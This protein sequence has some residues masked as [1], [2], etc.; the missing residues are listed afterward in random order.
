[1]GAVFGGLL[2]APGCAGVVDAARGASGELQLGVLA[3]T[4]SFAPS[5]AQ[6]GHYLPYFQAVYDP[7]IRL[8]PDGTV[9]PSLAAAWEYD[10]T[11]TRLSLRLRTDVRFTDGSPCD[12]AAIKANLDAFTADNGPLSS[13]LRLVERVETPAPDIAVVVLSAPDPGL[14]DS[15]GS[16]GGFVAS[17]AA[18]GGQ[19]L[20][21]R[22]VGSGPYLLDPAGTTIGVKYTFVRNPDH[23]GEQLPFERVVLNVIPDGRARLNALKAGQLDGAFTASASDA[24]EA[25]SAGLV[26]TTGPVNF[27][28]LIMFDRAGRLTPALADV[29][30]RRALSVAINREGILRGILLGMGERTGQ[31]FRP[32]DDGYLPELDAAF[33]YDPG[34]ARRLLAEAGHPGGLDIDF[35]VYSSMD[36]SIA[37]AIIANWA[38]VGVR[39]RRM[40]WAGDETIP[41]LQKA[42]ASLAYFPLAM[43]GTWRQMTNF[44]SEKA[45]W[46]PFKVAD[47]T[48]AGCIARYQRGDTAAAAELNRFLVDQ[49]WFAPFYRP[50]SLYLHN[51]GLAVQPQA[52]QATPALYNY[53][54]GRTA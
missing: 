10:D 26:N 6:L 19:G 2:A 12:A 9:A 35:P 1:M 24:V 17:P 32:G 40:E 4:R 52:R 53:A 37:D 42:Q 23:W 11:R 14:L 18:L 36:P 46:N 7:I 27:E 30:V 47:P 38:D 21:E 31:I 49:A 16:A 34:E 44:I 22:P 41:N 45:A 28:G 54:P 20:A 43:Q 5:Q 15:L 25:T 3:A 8:R 33:P 51:R 39:V 50:S 13:N 29:R 48:V